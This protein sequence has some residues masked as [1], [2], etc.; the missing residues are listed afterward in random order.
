MADLTEKNEAV[1][2]TEDKEK[3]VLGGPT[4]YDFAVSK[5]GL[6]V[7]PQPTSDPLDPLNWSK[8]K[9]HTILAIVMFKYTQVSSF[10]SW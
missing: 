1:M 5:D 6:A 9:K 4:S 2:Q 8:L 7:H 10:S 3:G